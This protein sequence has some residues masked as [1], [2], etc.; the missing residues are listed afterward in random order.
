MRLQDLQISRE[1]KLVADIIE[2]PESCVIIVSK[3]KAKIAELP[4][5][6]E[7]KIITDEG[8]VRRVKF[9]VGVKF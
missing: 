6:A 3:G 8:M 2:L 1:G 5:F 9:D 7:T 4:A